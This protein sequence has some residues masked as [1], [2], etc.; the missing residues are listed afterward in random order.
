MVSV[1]DGMVAWH[2][3]SGTQGMARHMV[4]G[5][6]DGVVAWHDTW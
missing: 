5:A 6:V 4:S 2:Y 1:V 3:T